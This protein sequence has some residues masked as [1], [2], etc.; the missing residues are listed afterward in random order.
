VAG[1]YIGCTPVVMMADAKLLETVLIKKV[2]DFRD[3]MEILPYQFPN[4]GIPH[5]LATSRGD[6][7]RKMRVALEP[8][9][10]TV[11]K[12]EVSRCITFC[13]C[14]P[15]QVILPPGPWACAKDCMLYIILVMWMFVHYLHLS[16]A[17]H[18]SPEFKW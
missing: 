6:Y 15:R 11:N 14:W 8:L 18:Y 13:H 17:Q 1:H 4:E 10:S 5:G 9:F 3:G 2:E 16:R 12:R 7:W